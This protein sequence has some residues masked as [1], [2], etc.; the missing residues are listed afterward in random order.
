[1]I[2]EV[3]N[4]SATALRGVFPPFGEMSAI[5]EMSHLATWRRERVSARAAYP[6]L[7]PASSLCRGGVS[8]WHGCP[9]LSDIAYG[10]RLWHTRC[11]IADDMNAWFPRTC[12]HKPGRGGAQQSGQR[13]P[14][15][16][17]P[18]QSSATT[19]IIRGWRL[20]RGS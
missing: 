6:V 8:W 2:E 12:S 9:G 17:L 10:V 18:E 4:P 20:C 1:M 15:T 19:A 11:R 5:L 13:I 16:P 7:K 14:P 3:S